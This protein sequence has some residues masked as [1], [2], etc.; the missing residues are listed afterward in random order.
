MCVQVRH[1]AVCIT[2]GYRTM[3]TYCFCLVNSSFSFLYFTVK[4]KWSQTGD[5]NDTGASSS[6]GFLFLLALAILFNSHPGWANCRS[7][8]RRLNGP[9][10]PVGTRTWSLVLQLKQICTFNILNILNIYWPQSEPEVPVLWQFSTNMCIVTPLMTTITL[11]V[12]M[13]A[14]KCDEAVLRRFCALSV[15]R[16]W[17]KGCDSSGCRERKSHRMHKKIPSAWTTPTFFVFEINKTNINVIENKASS[18]LSLFL[19]PFCPVP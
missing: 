15:M 17:S 3:S 12:H 19:S 18:A 2:D 1:V 13:H 9:P 11:N 8:S 16:F 10:Q 14:Q 7:A 5:L 6:S 4:L